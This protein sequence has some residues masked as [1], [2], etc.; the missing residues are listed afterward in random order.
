VVKRVRLRL[1]YANVVAKDDARERRKSRCRRLPS[2]FPSERRG[3]A[4]ALPLADP[5]AQSHSPA[6]ADIIGARR[7]RTG[8]MISSWSIPWR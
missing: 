2:R 8:A 3:S 4:G 6:L 7:A 5:V 1:T